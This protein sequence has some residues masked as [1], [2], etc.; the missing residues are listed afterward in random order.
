MCRH[1]EPWLPLGPLGGPSLSSELGAGASPGDAV[2]QKDAEI[3]TEWL[4][5][6]ACL[7]GYSWLEDSLAQRKAFRAALT[8]DECSREMCTAMDVPSEEGETELASIRAYSVLGK[9]FQ[10][11]RAHSF[12]AE[13]MKH[14]CQG[15]DADVVA[16]CVGAVM[17]CKLGKS[18]LPEEWLDQIR[19]GQRAALDEIWSQALDLLG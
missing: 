18:C 17:G 9:A 11:L 6:T 3:H 1:Y 8:T 4:C 14:V 5:R 19:P 10:G 2:Q 7:S 15:G 16:C 12:K 13:I